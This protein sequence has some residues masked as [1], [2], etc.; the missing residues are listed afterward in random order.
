ME[1]N[2]GLTVRDK[3]AIY[4]DGKQ[5]IPDVFDYVDEFEGFKIAHN[6]DCLT[7]VNPSGEVIVSEK[8]VIVCQVYYYGEYISLRK[9]NVMGVYRYDGTIVVPF[10]FYMT[11]ITDKGIEV[12]R[13][14]DDSWEHYN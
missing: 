11:F 13:N 6:P 9:N 12:K 14:E 3:K 7:I 2:L 10:E 8:D 1:K 5:L 4:L